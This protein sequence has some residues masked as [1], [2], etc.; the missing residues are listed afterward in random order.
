MLVETNFMKCPRDRCNEEAKVQATNK[1]HLNQDPHYRENTNK[2][3]RGLHQQTKKRAKKP[4]EPKTKQTDTSKAKCR[5][6]L[7]TLTHGGC[8]TGAPKARRE[9]RRG[10]SKAIFDYFL[11]QQKVI[12]QVGGSP[13]TGR[14]SQ[15]ST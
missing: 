4:N 1:P 9:F 7:F 11:A 3:N 6:H 12:A 14:K 13:D 8:L 15:N 2:S 5:T 10:Y